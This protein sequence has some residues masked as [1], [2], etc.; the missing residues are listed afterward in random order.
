[1]KSI[2]AFKGLY[3]QL[4]GDYNVKYI[5][6]LMIRLSQDCLENFL[7]Q[8]RGLGRHYDHPTPTSNNAFD[9]LLLISRN[10]VELD[11]SNV[12]RDIDPGLEKDDSV[13]VNLINEANIVL[14]YEAISGLQ[15]SD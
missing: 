10:S 12:E 9:F 1:M 4:R 13:T 7:S 11:N 14:N 3:C 8:I 5:P 2:A 15:T 6:V